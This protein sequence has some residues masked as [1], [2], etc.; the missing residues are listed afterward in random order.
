M[1]TIDY[2]VNLGGSDEQIADG[3]DGSLE[4]AAKVRTI[5]REM[6]GE[7]GCNRQAREGCE[8]STEC[9]LQSCLRVPGRMVGVKG[10][11]LSR[12]SRCAS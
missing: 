10:Y 11:T 5:L 6:I 4:A 3:L 12:H 7:F 9:T 8:P 1:P 2:V